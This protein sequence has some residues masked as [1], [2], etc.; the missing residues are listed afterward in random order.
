PQIGRWWQADPRPTLAESPYSMMG[1]NSVLKADFLGDTAIV[2]GAD[3]NFLRFQDDGKKRFSGRKIE[4]ETT[5]TN[6]DGTTTTVT[7]YSKFKLNDGKLVARAVK[8]GVIKK[9]EIVSDEKMNRQM[10]RSGV[11]TDA[12]RNSPLSYA[13]T[14]GVA[15]GRMDYAVQGA[16]AGDLNKNTLYVTGGVGYDIADF[17]NF[18]FGMGIG[19]LGIPSG[20]GETGGQYNH[21]FNSRRGNDA[22]PLFDLG[23]GTYGMPGWFDAASDQQAISNGY[24]NSPAVI[25]AHQEI[26]QRINNYMQNWRPYQN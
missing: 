9:V 21:I 13:K 10:E 11:R 23:P 5:T 20:F 14:Q 16:N 3:G 19:E 15:G 18:L 12:A 7:K 2:F 26:Q 6:A 8:N 25:K 22:T 24:S 4:S 17:G 1:N